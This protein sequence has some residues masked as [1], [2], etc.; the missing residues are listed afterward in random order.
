VNVFG[1]NDETVDY[2]PTSDN[3]FNEDA[4]AA[5]YSIAGFFWLNIQYGSL[6]NVHLLVPPSGILCHEETRFR[7]ML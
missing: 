3:D 1:V 5:K 7:I 2:T 6:K 4:I